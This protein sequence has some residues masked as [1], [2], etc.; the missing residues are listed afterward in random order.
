MSDRLKNKIRVNFSLNKDLNKYLTYASK[1]TGYAKTAIVEELLRL[2]LYGMVEYPEHSPIIR[3][4]DY[5]KEV[6]D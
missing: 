6:S 4:L 5:L 1:K 2:N 3:A